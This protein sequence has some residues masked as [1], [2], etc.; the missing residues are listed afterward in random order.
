MGAHPSAPSAVMREGQR[1]TLDEVVKTRPEAELGREVFEQ[2]GATLPFLLKVLAAETPLSLQAHPNQAQAE[3]GF[4][5]E[6]ARAVPRN[7][8]HRNYKDQNHKPELICALEPF[9]ALCGFKRPSE[10]RVRLAALGVRNLEPYVD[11][12][13]HDESARGIERIFR[14]LMTIPE[15]EKKSLLDA[16]VRTCRSLGASS[17]PEA[18]EY[19]WAAAL[20]DRY[21]GDVGC[22]TALLLNFVTLKPFEALYLP[23]GNLHAYLHGTGIEIMANSDNVLR[24]G[25]TPKYV[26][27]VELLKVLDF[28]AEPPPVVR[29]VRQGAELVYATPAVEFRLARID[30]DGAP[31]PVARRHS[32]EIVLCLNGELS[33]KNGYGTVALKSGASVWVP[34][35]EGPYELSGKATAFR[36]STGGLT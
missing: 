8:P 7:A 13:R 28:S 12:L 33:I 6:E 5:D 3:A 36:A 10:A 20:A 34:Y 17:A 31:V 16:V 27:V 9:E 21:P 18:A 14:A 1:R 2:F 4:L 26:D 23:A 30:V 29:A 32:G 19:R 24:G 11:I 35:F 15:G 22:V 25:L